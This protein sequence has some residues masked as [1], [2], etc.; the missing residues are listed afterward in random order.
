NSAPKALTLFFTVPG[1]PNTTGWRIHAPPALADIMLAGFPVAR[2]FSL[3]C[4]TSSADGAR[5]ST[6]LPL[7]A[8]CRSPAMAA[9]IWLF[10]EP[11]GASTKHGSTDLRTHAITDSCAAAWYGLNI[12]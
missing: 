1:V 11:V 4:V 6:R 12:S 8:S 2:Y 5:H 3:F 10:P 7:L 9:M